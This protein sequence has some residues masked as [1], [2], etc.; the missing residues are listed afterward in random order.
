[1][2]EEGRTYKEL[3]SFLCCGTRS[4]LQSVMYCEPCGS[5]EHGGVL[6]KSAGLDSRSKKPTRSGTVQAGQV[7]HRAGEILWGSGGV[8]HKGRATW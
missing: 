7:L 3:A 2:R 1:M 4:V 5:N 6:Q 8:P